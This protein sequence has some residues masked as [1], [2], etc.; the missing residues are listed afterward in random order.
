M[1]QSQSNRTTFNQVLI[2]A[3]GEGYTVYFQPPESLKMSYPC[4]VYHRRYIDTLDA[5]NINYLY[6]HQYQ[7]TLISRDP[8]DDAV[9]KL[10]N[11]KYSRY[12]SHSVVDG[13]NHDTFEIYY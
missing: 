8:D 3:L 5:D 6:Q 2:D 13:L 12:M 1:G 9:D 10:L 4:V 7:V 11:L